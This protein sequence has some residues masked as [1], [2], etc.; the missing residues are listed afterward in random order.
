MSTRILKLPVL[1]ALLVLIR[2]PDFHTAALSAASPHDAL[3]RDLLA[4]LTG[5]GSTESPSA[6]AI[7]PLERYPLTAT[8]TY[9]LFENEPAQLETL[10]PEVSKTVLRL[11][12]DDN[13]TGGLVRGM[14][15]RGESRTGALSPGFNA[16]AALELYSLHLIAW[17]TH[18]YEDAL[19]NLGFYERF[20]DSIT[21]SFYDPSRQL[22][23]P[24][25]MNG[26]FVIGYSPS[27]LLPL[28]TDATLGRRA[29]ERVAATFFEHA[30]GLAY[31]ER[32]PHDGEDPW[33]DTA[34]CP[35]VLALLS[36][37]LD[38]QGELYAMLRAIA[39]G[40]GAAADSTYGAWIDVW[41][42]DAA[43]R[44]RLFPP[45]AALSR[46]VN[47]TLLFERESLIESKEL[48]SLRAAADSLTM[49]LSSQ[50]LSIAAYA[51]AVSTVNRLIV[52]VSRI[53][54]LIDSDKERWRLVDGARWLR[55]SPRIKRIIHESLTGTITEL[56]RVKSALSNELERGAGI[57]F[58]VDL[59]VRPVV[60]GRPVD[61]SATLR[62]F[63][64]SLSA[65]HL[66]LQIGDQRWSMMDPGRTVALAPDGPPLRYDGTMTLPPTVEPGIMTL[67][68]FIDFLSAGRRIE[69]HRI[70]SIA[71]A[72]DCDA[73]LEMPQGKRVGERPV[74]VELV[75]TCRADRDMEGTV[76]GNFLREF[77]TTPSLPARFLVKN[78]SETTRLRLDVSPK[79]TLSPGRY[80]FSL[81]V[82]VDGK[83]IALFDETLVRP[84]RWL[85]LG[86]FTR[87]DDVLRN[88]LRYQ[89]D[90]TKTYRSGDGR[91]MR[92]REV[93]P[94]AIDAEGT[95][96]TES[97]FP[98]SGVP[99]VLLYTA[100]DAPSRANFRWKLKTKD[101]VA[102]WIN[103][104]I[105][106]SDE[107]NRVDEKGGPVEVRKGPNSLL[108][109]VCG[110]QAPGPLSFELSD[111]NGLPPANLNNELDTIIEGYER[112][113]ATE[114]GEQRHAP[115]EER[116]REVVITYRDAD[117]E[118]VSVIGSF[119]NW[120]PDATP[121][122]RDAKGFWTAR[123][124]LPPG[125]YAYKLL[126][127]RRMKIADPSGPATE[128]DGF[129][130][131]NSILEVR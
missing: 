70:E 121:M 39:E 75:L 19:E 18:A 94:Q 42:D 60:A 44:R 26:S 126:V 3:R 123:L 109:A 31:Q 130:G 2:P 54:E 111:D 98:A 69:I 20:S 37:A 43:V 105:M 107:A 35:T 116:V 100:I 59:P 77:A 33:G 47:L 80:P 85:E 13:L 50:T 108:I 89:S 91:T 83:P 97:L 45:W 103:G 55:L 129:G 125:K 27:Q 21:R 73:V 88:G 57:D 68:A 64:D 30:V 23:C 131:V 61:F 127:N 90:L 41:R 82:I 99:C 93:P 14:P 6:R 17:K 25:D 36:E 46:V 10:Y 29:H 62:V 15:G 87:S 106:P 79:G 9:L 92:W 96:R 104:E 12:T 76:E 86:P 52:R 48:S 34:L 71:L 72:S 95:L 32:N 113:T 84:F 122:K 51:E 4:R 81:R 115:P 49:A 7:E 78:D 38:R 114:V 1:I 120:E 56:T 102:L 63:R 53:A 24:I 8:T 101:T 110:E 28:V 128:P 11:F 58:G 117:A 40:G 65:S 67:D 22:F 118:E 112:L 66:A 124:A 5:G 119:N 16:L 74:P